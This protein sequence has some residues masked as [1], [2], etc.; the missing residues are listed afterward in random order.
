MS[1]GFCGLSAGLGDDA[2]EESG[3]WLRPGRLQHLHPGGSALGVGQH[4]AA[5]GA[6]NQMKIEG[7]LIGGGEGSVECVSEHRF[8][9]CA[10]LGIATLARLYAAELVEVCHLHHLPF[11][12]L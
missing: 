5:T 4:G 1:G 11:Y 2:L 6:T 7:G 8:T 9:L 10:M 3:G 12:T